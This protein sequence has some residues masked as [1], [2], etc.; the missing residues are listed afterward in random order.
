MADTLY[1]ALFDE[2]SAWACDDADDQAALDAIGAA[3]T[4]PAKLRVLQ[5]SSLVPSAL[6]E[7]AID[8]LIALDPG[9]YADA[10]PTATPLTP[11]A[12]APVAGAPAA[13]LPPEVR[14]SMRRVIAYCWD[15]EEQDFA[16]QDQDGREAHIFTSLRRL[17]TYLDQ[18][19]A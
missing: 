10:P 2:A 6:C 16:E 15:S 13:L 9:T 7:A 4:A 8:A 19:S 17:K 18:P 12:A 5:R 11:A 3:A 14:D 1:Q